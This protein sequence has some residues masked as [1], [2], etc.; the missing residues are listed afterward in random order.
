MFV[1]NNIRTQILRSEFVFYYSIGCLECAEAT[2]A[3]LSEYSVDVYYFLDEI[4][5]VEE[6]EVL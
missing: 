3:A 1:S 2:M 6:G 5:A 4:D